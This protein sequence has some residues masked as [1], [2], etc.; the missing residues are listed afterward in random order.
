MVVFG[1]KVHKFWGGIR[2]KQH[3][4]ILTER[5]CTAVWGGARHPVSFR[6][7]VII[8]SRYKWMFQKGEKGK[9][10]TDREKEKSDEEDGRPRY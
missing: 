3:L 10:K 8:C 2:R 5:H 1:C 6:Q 7:A 4:K 9:E